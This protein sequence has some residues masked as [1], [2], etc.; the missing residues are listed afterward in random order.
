MNAEDGEGQN[1]RW[2]AMSEK[3]V[4]G[5][6]FFDCRA[7]L[8]NR[9]LGK[10]LVLCSHQDASLSWQDTMTTLFFTLLSIY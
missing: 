7:H 6:I 4:F 5:G 10:Y 1:T 2:R 3:C 9:N 8:N